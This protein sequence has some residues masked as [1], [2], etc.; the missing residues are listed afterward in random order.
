M[1]LPGLH[2]VGFNSID[3]QSQLLPCRPCAHAHRNACCRASKTL[4]VRAIC[5]PAPCSSKKLLVAPGL[6]SSN[7][8]ATR[9]KGPHAPDWWEHPTSFWQM[10]DLLTFVGWQPT[11]RHISIMSI[12]NALE[13]HR[14]TT[15]HLVK[16]SDV[17]SSWAFGKK[18]LMI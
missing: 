14:N 11:A 7:I 8:D 16:A 13:I 5:Q 2:D 9:N 3:E 17:C 18:D 10:I 15:I 6:T 1:N 12:P 4:G